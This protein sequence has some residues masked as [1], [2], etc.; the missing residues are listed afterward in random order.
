M[1]IIDLPIGIFDSG[2]GGLTVFSA[3]AKKLPRENLLYL[4]DTARVPY[5]SRS[6]E[7]VLKYAQR[8][9]GHLVNRGVK[10]LIVACN[11][12]TTYALEYLQEAAQKENIPVLGVI[13]PGAQKAVAGSTNKKIGILGTDGT[14][15]GKRYEQEIH[16]I[17][18]HVTVIGQPCPLF[19]PLIEEGWHK[20]PITMQVA[21]R[22]LTNIEE[23]DTIILGCTHY[24]LIKPILEKVLPAVQ[25]IDSATAT[26]EQS[27]KVLQEKNLLRQHGKGKYR[28]LVTDN[29]ERFH[30]VGYYFLGYSPTP[31]QLIDL[32]EQDA[33]RLN[34]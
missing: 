11:T 6:P 34:R 12:A 1:D 20:D 15:K 13:A 19:V 25:F 17:N 3:V 30:R 18:P 4:G 16:K 26:A 14:I 32:E 28:F 31:I 24:P 27:Y 23:P 22:Y 29:M 2:V 10:A 8:V 21:K 9:A 5:G 7:T 33:N